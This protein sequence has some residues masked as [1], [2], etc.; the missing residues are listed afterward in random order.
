MTKKATAVIGLE[1]VKGVGQGGLKLIEGSGGGLAQV[2][3]ELGEGQ[4]DGV[5][6]G[7]VG[8]QV[9]DLGPAGGNQ[10]SHPRHLVGG[11]VVEDDLVARTQFGA[12]HLLEIGGED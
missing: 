8:R 4:L 10:L 1:G 6:V 2:G 9:V 7:A 11:E 12:E 5:Q 3:F